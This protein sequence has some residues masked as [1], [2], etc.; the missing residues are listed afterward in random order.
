MGLDFSLSPRFRLLMT[1][2]LVFA[3]VS[4]V[5]TGQGGAKTKQMGWTYQESNVLNERLKLTMHGISSCVAFLASL[6]SLERS[7]QSAVVLNHLHGYLKPNFRLVRL[8]KPTAGQG[9]T[10]R[11]LPDL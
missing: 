11:I 3:L 10:W 9:R 5:E 6:S 7:K 8:S 4:L 2:A 1:G